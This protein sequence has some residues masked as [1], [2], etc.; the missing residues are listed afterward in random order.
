MR[1]AKDGDSFSS[2]IDEDD[3][4]DMT[5]IFIYLLFCNTFMYFEAGSVPAMLLQIARSFD[6]SPGSQGLLGGIVYL[7]MCFGGPVAGYCLRRYEQWQPRIIALSITGNTLWTLIWALT[8]S[9]YSHSSF[10]FI[11]IR[12]IMGLHLNFT[13]F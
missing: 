13:T 2:D 1:W 10:L 5:V 11:S 8:P 7:A 4:E 6:M 3:N 9:T 12:F